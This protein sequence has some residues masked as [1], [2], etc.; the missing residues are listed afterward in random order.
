MWIATPCSPRTSNLSLTVSRKRT[1]VLSRRVI[2][3]W[4]C[5]SLVNLSPTAGSPIQQASVAAGCP[6]SRA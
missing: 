5:P 2:G 4:A 3:P 1:R 6:C